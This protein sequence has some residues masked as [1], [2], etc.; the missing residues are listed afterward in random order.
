MQNAAT[1]THGAGGDAL[2]IV[3][4]VS[5][6]LTKYNG[7]KAKVY[8]TGSSSGAMMTNILA[9]SYPDVF[10]AGSAYSGVA[11]ACFAGSNAPPTPFSNNQT[12]AQGLTHTAAEWA[13]Y[14][15]NS[16]PA[17]TGRRTR[18]QI[19]HG[20]ADT[21]VRPQCAR[22]AL[23]QWAAVNNLTLTKSSTGVPSSA[24]QQ[25]SYGDGSQLVGYF[26]TGVGHFAPTNEDNMLKF[27]GLI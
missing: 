2:G 22:E 1:L 10:E 4:M 19:W 6:T 25:D 9:G 21:L 5:Y 26:G 12:C 16:Y 11:H 24:W 27:F 13:N 14:V 8:V 3:N 20:L 18:M 7:N 23:K 17:Y 15:H